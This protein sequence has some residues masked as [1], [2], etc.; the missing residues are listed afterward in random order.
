ML[1]CSPAEGQN[2]WI[3]EE[4]VAQDA[5]QEDGRHLAEAVR[6][7]LASPHWTPRP[8]P[9]CRFDHTSR[10]ARAFRFFVL[11]GGELKYF[12]NEKDAFLSNSQALKAIPLHEVLCAI[13]NP[14]HHDMFV[15]DLGSEKKVKL[16]ATS[17]EN[18]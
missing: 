15:I 2:A 17:E 6:A 14:K 10:R 12:K 1:A 13:V 16:Q 9:A 8:V 7:P 18:R 5:G 3:A 4:E 11:S